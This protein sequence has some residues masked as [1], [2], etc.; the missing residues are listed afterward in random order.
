MEI[1][2]RSLLGIAGGTT[3]LTACSTFAK[4]SLEPYHQNVQ[5][6]HGVASG[7]PLHDQVIL[8]TRVTPDEDSP[9]PIAVE[10]KVFPAKGQKVIAQYHIETSKS[11]DYCVKVDATGLMPDTEYRYRFEVLTPDGKRKSPLG[12]TKTTAVSGYNKVKLAAVSCSN[13]QFGYFNV[14]KE[15]GQ[16]SDLDVI[17]HLG[18]YLYEYGMNGYG[19]E[20]AQALGRLHEPKEEIVSLEQYR[21]RH[22]QYK[23]DPDLQSAHAV[24]PWICTW[25]DHESANNSYRTGAE[26]HQTGEEGS[27]TDRKQVAVQAYLE[28]MPVRDPRTGE[29]HE[30]IYRQFRFGDIATIF[31]LESRLTGR[32]TEI[33]WA[34]ELSRLEPDDDLR[35]VVGNVLRKVSS[36]TRT[37]LGV[38]QEKWLAD[39]LKSSVDEGVSW[40]VL[41]NQVIMAKVR[42]PDFTKTLTQS[43]IDMQSIP[44]IQRLIPFSAL[45]LP[46]NLDAWDGFPVA[47][48]RLY[49]AAKDAKA[50]L[51]TLTGDTHTAWVNA[52]V[53]EENNRLG[54]E[55]GCTSVTSP[56]L[57]TYMG[58]IPDLGKQ[59][60]D[61]NDQVYYHDPFGNGATVVTLEKD[62]VSSVFLKV[63]TTMHSG[64]MTERAASFSAFREENGVSEPVPTESAM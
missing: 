25:D 14:Y 57:G 22:A 4:S 64:Y 55:F 31:A 39:G 16:M 11:S 52:L 35:P 34:D 28:W 27:W 2:R 6:N 59:F 41:A 19:S 36:P 61:A 50:R 45:G 24:A 51:V 7:D 38:T 1:S 21:Q 44:L 63:S 47:R 8:W 17:V 3:L 43:Q 29:N 20:V 37:M 13:W 46:F 49:K 56:G 18:D 23:S 40:Q 62:K 32:S 54:V 42:P 9:E 26:N 5:F 60:V 15:L 12:R 53:D 33:S 48:S 10:C 30:S 58:D